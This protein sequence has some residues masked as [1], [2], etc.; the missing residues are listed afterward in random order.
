[1]P[2]LAAAY[3]LHFASRKLVSLYVAAKKAP[4][5][6]AASD[7]HALSAG[8]KAYTTRFTAAAL[9]TCREATGGHGYAASNRLG[10]WRSDHDIF[11]T[12]EGDN[13]VLLQ[14]V[15]GLL[16]KR[17]QDRFSAHPLAASTA[18]VREWA[19]RALPANPLL[20]HDTSDAHLRDP[21]FLRAALRHRVRRLLFTAAARLSKHTRRLGAFG[22]WSKCVPHLLHLANAHVEAVVFDEF[23]AAAAAAPTA[24]GARAALTTLAALFALDRIEADV[25]YRND[26][27][28]AADKAKA[29][30]KLAA[31]LRAQARAQA[32]PLV[33]AFA[34]PDH[35]LRAPIG[36]SSIVDDPYKA[37]L[38]STGFDC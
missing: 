25:M 13:T 7:V 4:G 31:R 23:S 9:S 2:L 20:A 22:A 10:G 29:I 33:D 37:Y 6:D 38:R 15:A 14:Q 26:E 19:G 27:Y 30:A 1:M 21:A 11:Q 12:F 32:L 28:V 24:G 34:I 18:Y 16:L 3:G 5:D 35:I 17:Y 8:L 36:V